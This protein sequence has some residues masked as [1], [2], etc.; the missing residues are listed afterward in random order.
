LFICNLNYDRIYGFLLIQN[1][2]K[3]LGF[4][5]N[6]MSIEKIIGPSLPP[7]MQQ[8]VDEIANP[9]KT[10]IK[11]EKFNS[12]AHLELSKLGFTQVQLER[13]LELQY[14]L[15]KK[16]IELESESN[17]IVNKATKVL[18]SRN[19]LLGELLGKTSKKSS[20]NKDKNI[21]N[22]AY[23][24]SRNKIV[25]EIQAEL[26][27]QDGEIGS[28]VLFDPSANE[29]EDEAVSI[30]TTENNLANAKPE[31]KKQIE[32]NT[33][34]G[35]TLSSLL[36]RYDLNQ[37]FDSPDMTLDTTPDEVIEYYKAE[38]GFAITLKE[39][40]IKSRDKKAL[41]GLLLPEVQESDKKEIER[42]KLQIHKQIQ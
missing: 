10:K 1:V 14:V 32:S 11:L 21:K 16:L 37:N 22:I 5:Y 42:I 24:I 20:Q 29:I 34:R 7:E 28:T 25:D 4:T 40:E 33:L 2:N 26:F 3:A 41:N 35:V 31:L 9:V 30:I 18:D 23:E 39:A 38:L 8:K 27:S 15:A 19:K 6:S 36:S 17:E 12:K 13:A